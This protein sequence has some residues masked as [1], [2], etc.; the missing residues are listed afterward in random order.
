MLLNSFDDLVKTIF[1]NN[2][3]VTGDNN[4]TVSEDNN[5]TVTKN[6]NE[7]VTEDNDIIVI[8]YHNINGDNSNDSDNNNNNNENGSDNDDD[9]KIKQ[10]NN[11]FEKID[12]TKLFEEQINLLKEIDDLYEY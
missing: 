2:K 8:K 4:K 7:I 10:I 1:N 11:N 9:Y 12:E 3:I 6:N 5:I